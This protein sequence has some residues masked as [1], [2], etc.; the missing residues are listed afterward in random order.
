MLSPMDKLKTGLY[1]R[2]AGI[3]S[4]ARVNPILPTQEKGWDNPVRSGTHTISSQ[5][6]DTT[7]RAG[8]FVAEIL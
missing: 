3:V 6:I 1:E 4:N 8:L 5:V 7:T 2:M